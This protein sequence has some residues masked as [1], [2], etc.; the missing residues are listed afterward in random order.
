MSA[1]KPV[2]SDT[3]VEAIEVMFVY[4]SLVVATTGEVSVMMLFSFLV[5]MGGYSQKMVLKVLANGMVAR[6]YA[7]YQGSFRE[8]LE[9][10]SLVYIVSPGQKIP[11]GHG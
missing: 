11:R 3:R 4:T 9:R 1:A 10:C 2:A 7:I 5:G 6:M 8:L